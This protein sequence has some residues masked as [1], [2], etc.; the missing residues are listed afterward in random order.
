MLDDSLA[1]LLDVAMLIYRDNL[2]GDDTSVGILT[3]MCGT[4]N[5]SLIKELEAI[6]S[7]SC[8]HHPAGRHDCGLSFWGRQYK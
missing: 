4:R 1:Q 2:L 6:E 3:K 7:C 8:G 5:E